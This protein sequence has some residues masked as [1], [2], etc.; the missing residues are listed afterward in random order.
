M[1]IRIGKF[2]IRV[3]ASILEKRVGICSQNYDKT[4]KH[5]LLWDFDYLKLKDIIK[6][7]KIVQETYCLPIIYII[8]SSPDSYH[9]YSFTARTFRET[10]TILSATTTLDITYLRMGIV[11][12]Y[13]TLRISP[14]K[15]ESMFKLVKKIW[16]I[17]PDE[18]KYNDMTINEYLT[19]N[20]GGKHKNEK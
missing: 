5:I 4:D 16:S 12:G 19:S 1:R 17:Y 13:F 18:A 20:K 8:K 3:Y 15:N 6:S 11:R 10:I 14:R 7:L 9:A 2:Q